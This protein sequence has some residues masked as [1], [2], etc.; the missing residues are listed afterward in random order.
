MEQIK[1]LPWSDVRYADEADH[2][3]ESLISLRFDWNVRK[4]SYLL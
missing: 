4:I 3:S 1:T 2:Y